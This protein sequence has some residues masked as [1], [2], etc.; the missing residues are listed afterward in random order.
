M[1]AELCRAQSMSFWKYY[2]MIVKKG[3]CWEYETIST[4]YQI[5]FI[6][7]QVMIQIIP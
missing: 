2:A 6:F 3:L 1:Q 5:V 4:Q 7:M